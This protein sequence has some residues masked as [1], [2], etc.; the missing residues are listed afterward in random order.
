M[1]RPKGHHD[2]GASAWIKRFAPLIPPEGTVLDLACGLG[3]HSRYLLRRGH[4]VVALDIDVS[5]LDKL[6]HRAR[7]EIV[8]TD[9]EAGEPWPLPGRRF[10]AVVV[11]N[12]LYRP[13][14]PELLNSVEPGGVLL[15]ETFAA[16]NECFGRPR[17]PDHLL[18]RGE[19]LEL[20][21][22]H[23]VII[24]Y[25]DIVVSG[26]RRAAVQRVCARQP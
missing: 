15:Y 6:R 18:Q 23:M 8:Q 14:F 3:R 12:Y 20:L 25:E 24:A 21:R 1:G 19:L 2:T 26:E 22:G 9:L 7:L 13:I 17:N 5:A 4:P 16:G 11:T 10:A